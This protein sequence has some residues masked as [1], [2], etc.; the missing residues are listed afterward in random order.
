M[1]S[2]FKH[3]TNKGG[4]MEIQ[5]KNF[6]SIKWLAFSFL[7]I[8]LFACS[9][10][11]G[12]TGG[13]GGSIST[14]SIGGTVSGLNGTGLVL[15]NNGTDD[16]NI[17][18]NGNFTF[19]SELDDSENYSVTVATQPSSPDQTCNVS[20]GSGM[21]S[22]SN[23]ANVIV[24]CT[25]NS[26]NSLFIDSGQTFGSDYTEDIELVDVDGDGDVD[27]VDANGA[28][29]NTVWLNDGD[30]N[31]TDSGQ[32]L[33]SADTYSMASGDVD[34]DGDIDLVAGNYAQPSIVWLN[35]GSGLFSD[36][37]QQLGVT[38]ETSSV[39][40]GDVDGDSDLDLI[41]GLAF[42]NAN[43]IW[44]NNGSGNFSNS[45]QSF[46]NSNTA[47]VVL[48]DIDGDSDLDLIESNRLD[49]VSL[50][51]LNDGAGL[52]TDSGQSLGDNETFGVV[53][54]DIDGDGDLDL[55]EGTLSFFTNNSDS[56]WINDGSGL[57]S[58]SG[59]DHGASFTAS[60]ALG[61]VD[62]DGDLD[63]IKGLGPIAGDSNTIWLND[64]SGT[65]TDSAENF[66]GFNYTTAL[67]LGDLDG[68]GDLD[69]VTGNNETV[70]DSNYIFLNQTN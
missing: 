15:Q 3:T 32:L 49:E 25:N 10:G 8:L 29:S 50:V 30:A 21:I 13:S 23:I 39:A 59:Q 65:F 60:L 19:S 28:G 14:Y 4:V 43:I 63:L 41:E 22:G 42:N 67:A 53:L 51:W 64:G 27:I 5:R 35:D 55:V 12:D 1:R 24:N 40:L 37:G 2:N 31:F 46:G 16:L 34:G 68:D 57:F 26:S 38:S 52:F 61:D 11:D 33:G 48:G 62:N 56:V 18:I 66:G 69:V 47:R 54:G 7:S 20:S 36:S 70:S 44:L 17:T 6:N 58:D 9:G 45:G